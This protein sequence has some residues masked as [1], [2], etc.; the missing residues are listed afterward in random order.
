MES[1]TESVRHGSHAGTDPAAERASRSIR[2]WRFAAAVSFASAGVLF[3]ADTVMAAAAAISLIPAGSVSA[4]ADVI[5]LISSLSL[6]YFGAH[7]LDRQHDIAADTK[8][9]KAK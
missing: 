2:R 9:R 4:S 6:T 8:R 3:L 7:C 5:L 1:E